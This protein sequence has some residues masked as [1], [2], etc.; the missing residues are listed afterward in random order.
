MSDTNNRPNADGSMRGD[1]SGVSSK[2]S[3]TGVT[4]TYGASVQ[5]SATNRKGGISG[6]TGSDAMDKTRADK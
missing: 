6:A 4:D 3:T 2:G 5:P 1:E